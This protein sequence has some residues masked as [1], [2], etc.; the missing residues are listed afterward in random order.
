MTTKQKEMDKTRQ[1]CPG[2]EGFFDL[3]VTEMIATPA[4]NTGARL[5]NDENRCSDELKHS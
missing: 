4:L 3:L 2:Y 5:F 1:S